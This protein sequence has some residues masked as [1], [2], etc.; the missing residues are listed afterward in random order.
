MADLPVVTFA[1][2]DEFAAW[3]EANHASS[4]G[5]VDQGGQEEL[6]GPPRWRRP[7]RSTSRSATAG[8]TASA[9]ASTRRTSCRSTRRGGR[10]AGGRRS[11][12]RKVEA[13]IAAGEMRPAGLA[14][15]ER[16]KADGRWDAAYDS[17]RNMQVPP[18]LQAELDKD[19]AAAAFFASLDSQSTATR[20]SIAST[21]PSGRRPARA[22]S[23][24]TST[25]SSAGRS[26]TD[27]LEVAAAQP[28]QSPQV[29]VVP[30][31]VRRAGDEPVRAVVGD[32]HPVAL[33][34]GGDDPRLTRDTTR[35]RPT[36]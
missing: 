14:E 5:I 11:T 3:M 24:S 6:R 4:D 32:E 18:D 16:A 33:E 35:G 26:F 29:V 25:R 10:A 12:S 36:A 31:R 28:L 20:S 1:S 8:S 34:R 13:L 15:I 19:P 22:G 7:R 17:P 21:T 2:R 9:R 30:A 23:R 27:D